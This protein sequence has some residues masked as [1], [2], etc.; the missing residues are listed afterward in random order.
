MRSLSPRQSHTEVIMRDIT[1][2]EYC[3]SSTKI[4]GRA[5]INADPSRSA[6]N[7]DPEMLQEDG[8]SDVSCDDLPRGA[9][10]GT[11]A[12]KTPK[13]DTKHRPYV[14]PS[15]WRVISMKDST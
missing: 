4:H 11:V 3:S 1:T 14:I 7:D 8:I 10:F 5:H 9:L 2:I 15:P 13:A 6:P 12:L